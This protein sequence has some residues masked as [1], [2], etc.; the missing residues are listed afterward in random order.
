MVD[1]EIQSKKVRE[2]MKVIYI[3]ASFNFACL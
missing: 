3:D 1:A 2:E